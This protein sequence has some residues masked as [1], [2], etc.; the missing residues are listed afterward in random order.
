M[1]HFTNAQRA[2][3]ATNIKIHTM[4]NICLQKSTLSPQAQMAC[5][6][7]WNQSTHYCRVMKSSTIHIGLGRLLEWRNEK[8]V[9]VREFQTDSV[10]PEG[11]MKRGERKRT[12]NGRENP[13]SLELRVL[14]SVRQPSLWESEWYVLI[15]SPYWRRSQIATYTVFMFLAPG[16]TAIFFTMQN[17]LSL[18]ALQGYEGTV[19]RNVEMKM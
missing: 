15:S 16:K 7:R 6:K 10:I 1:R 13:P 2:C 5:K 12:R 17:I 19:N 11:N 3:L 14:W 4:F 18:T 8:P 9:L